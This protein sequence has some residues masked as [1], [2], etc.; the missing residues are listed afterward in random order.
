MKISVEVVLKVVRQI[1]IVLGS[2][3][4]WIGIQVPAEAQQ[5]VEAF[6][7]AVG[8]FVLAVGMVWSWAKDVYKWIKDR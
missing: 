4:T 8:P 5:G 1:F 2:V 7:S 3:G 6:V